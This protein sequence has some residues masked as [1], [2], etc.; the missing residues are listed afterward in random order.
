MLIK[1]LLVK[2]GLDAGDY[3]KGLTDAQEATTGGVG[4]IV[5]GLS[6]IGGAV[7][8]GA[9]SLAAAAVIGIGTAAW[10][11]ANALDGAFDSIA[12]VWRIIAMRPDASR[13]TVASTCR[14]S[15]MRDHG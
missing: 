4:S 5:A 3:H 12:I 9:L 15:S 11:S 13:R 1:T 10:T 6:S 2:L 7:V 14:I 8:L